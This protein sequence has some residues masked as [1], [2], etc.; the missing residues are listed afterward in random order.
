MLIDFNS[1]LSSFWGTK[2]CVTL[3][4]LKYNY[5]NFDFSKTMNKFSQFRTPRKEFGA[6]RLCNQVFPEFKNQ[7]KYEVIP[8][9]KDVNSFDA[10]EVKHYEMKK[11]CSKEGISHDILGKALYESLSKFISNTRKYSF[12]NNYLDC[13]ALLPSNTSSC[14]PRYQKKGDINNIKK[15]LREMTD[16]E[17]ASTFIN[18]CLVLQRFPTTIFHRFTPKLKKYNNI[19]GYK[20]EYKIRQI[21][22]VS[23]FICAL[24][25]KFLKHFI[26]NFKESMKGICTIGLTRIQVSKLISNLRNNAYKSGRVIMCGDIKGCDKSVTAHFHRAF[27]DTLSSHVPSNFIRDCILA[28]GNY[29]AFT[30]VLRK[31]SIS[32]THGSTLSGSWITSVFNTFV[33]Y[34]VLVYSYLYLYNR[35]PEVSEILVQGDDFVI[36]IDEKDEDLIAMLFKYFNLNIKESLQSICTPSEDIEFLGFKWD[37][38]NAPYQANSWF[39]SRIV[40]PEQSVDI[41]GTERIIVRYIS[42][43][44]QSSNFRDLFKL[45][46]EYDEYLRHKLLYEENPVF[47]FLDSTGKITET[48]IPFDK[49][50]NLG[51]R[52]F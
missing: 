31:D 44:F 8:N 43:I 28:L 42:L 4:N 20:L 47:R 9:Q 38:F 33:V 14:Y 29:H 17:K 39:Y 34:T 50:L 19:G 37:I 18:K 11:S 16:F 35:V 6:Q 41:S 22:G 30:P 23:H 52:L 25:V 27:F 3:R 12:V 49:L 24:E 1:M 36:V 46:Y 45:F 32:I 7:I 15:V 21:F 2:T 48:Y 13:V 40:Y 5:K 10:Y 51:W 26:D